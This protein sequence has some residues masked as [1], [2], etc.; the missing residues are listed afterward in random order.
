MHAKGG[1]RRRTRMSGDNS[2]A[3]VPNS[4]RE[5]IT[6][7]A[8]RIWIRRPSERWR[9]DSASGGKPKNGAQDPETIVSKL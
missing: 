5:T 7:V 9:T 8:N 6:A 4:V 1:A 2:R 3:G